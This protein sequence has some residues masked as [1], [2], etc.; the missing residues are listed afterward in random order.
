V[1]HPLSLSRLA[2]HADAAGLDKPDVVSETTSRYQGTL[3]CA[4]LR[5][6]RPAE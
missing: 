1:P 5:R 6:Q 4:V 3:F 2:Q